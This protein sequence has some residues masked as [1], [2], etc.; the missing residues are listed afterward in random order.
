MSGNNLKEARPKDSLPKV[1][2]LQLPEIVDLSNLEKIEAQ[3]GYVQEQAKRIGD[4]VKKALT[5]LKK[6][7]G[8]SREA[9]ESEEIQTT[10]DALNQ[11][12]WKEPTKAYGRAAWLALFQWFF[13]QEVE[14]GEWEVIIQEMLDK[15]Y[16]RKDS[17]AGFSIRDVRF[18]L[19]VGIP[20]EEEDVEK[21]R[22]L[23]EIFSKRVQG[24]R[25]RGLWEKAQS[26]LSQ[27]QLSLP[28]FLDPDGK[29]GKFGLEIPVRDDSSVTGT[30]LRLDGTILCRKHQ[31]RVFILD[32][33][34]NVSFVQRVKTAQDM[35]IFLRVFT[36]NKRCPPGLERL[37]DAG[38][39]EEGARALRGL[40]FIFD[41]GIRHLQAKEVILSERERM[42]G[43]ATLSPREFFLELNQGICL[44]EY[45][46][47]WRLPDNGGTISNLFFLVE[48]REDKIILLEAPSHLKDFLGQLVGIEFR[49]TVAFIVV[50]QPLQAVLR[51]VYGLVQKD[52]VIKE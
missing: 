49:D 40:W 50:P 9:R 20:L 22:R 43:K 45:P 25:K 26:L 2:N 44:V 52:Q 18:N 23:V 19:P 24:A 39:S 15:G 27:N 32:V 1:P 36:L 29:D 8:L 38:L 34:G 48:R 33:V 10:V 28:Q 17:E 4:W 16:L 3:A 12:L 30:S 11:L 13:T 7:E 47:V 51:A 6:V 46:G 21:F 37:K 14:G 41:R 5:V 42:V 31:G 35:E